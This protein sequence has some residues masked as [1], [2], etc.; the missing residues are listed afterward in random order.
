[1]KTL[2]TLAATVMASPAFAATDAPFFSLR[3]T[4]L[5]VGIAFLIFVGILVWAKVPGRISGML[6][7]RST[8]IRNEL[9]EAKALREEAKA[10]LASYERKQKDVAE[11]SERIVAKARQEAKAAAEQAKISLQEAVDR[12]V[13]GAEDQIAA[14]EASAVRE[15]RER[16]IAVAVEAAR[17]V[18]ARQM[19]PEARSASI[20][21]SI[22]QVAQKLH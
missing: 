2:F 15:V 3:N 12:R 21:R 16:A 20:D 5:T 10:L 9:D 4:N 13:R 1:M 22:D 7:K 19:T 6:D 8:D 11:Q 17:D 14:A 18:L